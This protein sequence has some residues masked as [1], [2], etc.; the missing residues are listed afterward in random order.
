MDEPGNLVSRWRKDLRALDAS[1]SLQ[2]KIVSGMKGELDRILEHTQDIEARDVTISA[3][4]TSIG[5]MQRE[6]EALR[7]ENA[8][9]KMATEPGDILYADNIDV[10]S[11]RANVIIADRIEAT[12]IVADI[13]TG[14]VKATSVKTRYIK[15]DIGTNF[16]EREE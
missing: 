5:R 12:G 9:L 8:A 1:I 2:E 15:G 6:L 13:I 4:A 3:Q 11:L 10:T 16:V 7:A 14:N